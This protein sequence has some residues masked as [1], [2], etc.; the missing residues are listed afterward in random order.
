MELGRILYGAAF[1]GV[2]ALGLVGLRNAFSDREPSE[3][4]RQA[5]VVEA[6]PSAD[7]VR[8]EATAASTVVVPRVDE[9]PS[10][11]PE[12]SP[13]ARLNADAIAALEAGELERAVELLERCVA[14]EPDEPIFRRNLAEALARL[15]VRDHERI[16]PC[17][18]CIDTLARAVELAPEREALAA[19]LER[20]R[21][22]LQ[23]ESEFQREQSM[24]FELAYEVW[25]GQ[26][27]DRAA[28]LLEALEG[29]YVDLALIFG[30][31]PAEQGRPRIPVSL[32]RPA[33][34]S[35]ITGLAEWTGASYDGVIRA[36]IADGREVGAAFDE[37]LR[38]E[39]IHAFVRELGGR[40]TPG[41]LNEGLAQWFQRAPAAELSRAR[42]ALRGATRIDL[43]RLE[44][45]LTKLDA[46]N[47]A[48]AYAQSLAFCAWIERQ[49]GREVLVAMVAGC[50]Q[51]TR[52]DATFEEWTRVALPEAFRMFADEVGALEPNGER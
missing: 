11:A 9:A 4:Q 26:L 36:P 49:Y 12:H 40:T 21:R 35:N 37:V 41:W 15:A 20:W 44:G 32:Y 43:A 8:R 42:T 30:V 19:L 5:P 28:D 3:P 45:P 52:V 34:F 46:A 1:A 7:P 48:L 22:E 39:L 29:H 47:A 24:H 23:T 2:L 25:R 50:A 27:L 6:T 10:A 16:R 51:K 14:G 13:F 33:E 38:H 18:A 17:A 31:R